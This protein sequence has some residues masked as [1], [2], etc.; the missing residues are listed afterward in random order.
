MLSSI[1]IV[2]LFYFFAFI[3]CHICWLYCLHSQCGQGV[4]RVEGSGVHGGYLVVI[5]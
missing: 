4:Q 1:I 3:F 5:E 2:I